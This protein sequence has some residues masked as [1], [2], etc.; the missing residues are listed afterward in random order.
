MQKISGRGLAFFEIDGS[1]VE[2]DLMPGQQMI[3]D[4]GNLALMEESCQMDVVSVKG[5]KNVLFGG[6][7]FFNTVVTGPGKI[8]LQTMPMTAFVAQIAAQIPSK[9]N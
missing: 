5:A 8:T 4:T 9:S 1:A 6:E 2:Y 7:G 3:V